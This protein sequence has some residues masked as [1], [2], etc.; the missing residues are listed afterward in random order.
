MNYEKE[1][2]QEPN[3]ICLEQSIISQAD[4]QPERFHLFLAHWSAAMTR[5]WN[6]A[7]PCNQSFAISL[8]YFFQASIFIL[9]SNHHLSAA[10]L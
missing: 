3:A 4:S 8:L 10:Y 5:K 6:K 2:S 7:F 1:F 9:E